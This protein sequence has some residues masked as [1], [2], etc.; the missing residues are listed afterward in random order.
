MNLVLLGP[1]ASGKG[2]CSNYLKEKYHFKHISMGDLL[3]DFA[4]ADTP[5]AKMVNETISNGKIL[6]EELTTKILYE[7]LKKNNLFDNI[8]LDGYPR[9]L[10][11]V[12]LVQKF[13]KID[14][15]IILQ[16]DYET[17][18]SRILNRI[19]CSKCGKVFSLTTYH[20]NYCDECG[21]EL[22]RRS[23]DN[24][25]TL[26]TRMAEY[27]RL[28]VPVINYFSKLGLVYKLDANEDYIKQLD[29]LMEMVKWI[30]Y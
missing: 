19:S 9:G 11:S 3:R 1:P 27:E 13:L 10:I 30:F 18:K 2:T 12:E 28:T 20:K 26:N 15:V 24:I 23:D 5:L 25:D 8:L 29:K 6:D 22:K 14:K 16:A 17:I 21:G 7:Y 4:N